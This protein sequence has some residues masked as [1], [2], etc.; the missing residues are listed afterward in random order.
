M[1]AA[2]NSEQTSKNSQPGHFDR[3]VFVRRI[4]RSRELTDTFLGACKNQR[5]VPPV[6]STEK[7]SGTRRTRKTRNEIAYEE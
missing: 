3:A 4:Q 6:I 2:G 1:A 5:T 7:E